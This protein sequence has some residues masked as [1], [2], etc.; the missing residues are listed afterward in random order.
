MSDTTVNLG[1][2]D[3]AHS[4]PL[5][6]VFTDVNGNA[7]APAAVRLILRP[8]GASTPT[9]ITNGFDTSGG[10]NVYLYRYLPVANGPL[11]GRWEADTNS[12]TNAWVSNFIV[13]I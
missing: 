5:Q 9:V 4:L 12:V 13:T 11:S 2:W 6:A 7:L 10:T 1:T 8:P 3:I